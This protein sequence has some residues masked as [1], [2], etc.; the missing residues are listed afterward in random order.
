MMTRGIALAAASLL[1]TATPALAN[2][3][4]AGL[5]AGGLEFGQTEDVEMVSEDLF[6]S[7]GEVAVDYV[8]R[9][10]SPQ[11]VE[12][13]VAFQLPPMAPMYAEMDTALPDM[14]REAGPLNYMSFTA[15][16]DGEPVALQTE[17]RFYQL[18]ADCEETGWGLGFFDTQDP[19]LTERLLALGV[20]DSYDLATIR[21]WFARLPAAERR[22][23]VADG[24]FSTTDLGPMP[25]YWM[26]VRFFW[27]QEFPGHSEVAISHT[28][29]PVL[30]ATVPM[31]DQAMI[32]GFCID[33]DTQR[34][35][36]RAEGRNNG[37]QYLEYVLKT[38]GTWRGPI[39][40]FR[41]T[42]D[43]SDTSDIVSFCAS[44]VKK[45]S[46]TTFVVEKRN[47]SPHD[48]VRILFADLGPAG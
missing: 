26:S 8:F 2:D 9:N 39:G 28:Y 22:A 45:T 10:V 31:M 35:L 21:A 6:L 42:V 14:V 34:S 29:R 19:E 36:R 20:P 15:V 27:R 17:L 18:C 38:A 32:E 7:R 43:K 5:G 12:T 30:G 23:L 46:P 11:D 13:W 1:W 44:G 48:D 40:R 33:K 47:Y 24:I 25:M 16:V 4:Y 41:M 37:Q 3:G